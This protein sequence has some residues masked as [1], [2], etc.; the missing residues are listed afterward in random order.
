MVEFNSE[1][2]KPSNPILLFIMAGLVI[3]LAGGIAYYVHRQREN[4]SKSKTAAIVVPGLLTAGD[5]NFEYYKT[6]VRIQNVGASLGISLS[7]S[8]TAFISGILL[9]DG[10]R[11]L[12][13]VQLHIILYDV[14]GKVSKE[15]TAF[16]LRPG[17]GLH[18]LMPLEK[19]SFD[20]GVD[21]VERNWNPK[22]ISYEITGLKYH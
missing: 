19:R 14:Q 5:A 8:R 2:Q 13:A 1:Q 6:R 18:P 7:N 4:P 17:P 12:E 15:R 20:I 21:S 22:L 11:T 16:I 9:N 10:D 3:L